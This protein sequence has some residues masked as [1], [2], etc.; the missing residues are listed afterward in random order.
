ME[1]ETLCFSAPWSRQVFLEEFDRE[2]AYLKVIR[3]EP[4]GLVV[5]FVNYWVVQDEV[6]VLNVATHPSWRRQ[7]LGRK[8]MNHVLRAARMRSARLITLEVRRSNR[9]AIELYRSLGFDSVGVRPRYYEN[10]ED[11][12]V[13]LK[14]LRGN[15]DE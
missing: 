4:D 15:A 1:I 3:R 14:R 2:F 9:P 5:A 6:H 10:L 8:M 13:M 11:A 7:G 12:I